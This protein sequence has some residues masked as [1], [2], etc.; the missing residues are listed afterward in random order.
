MKYKNEYA[1]CFSIKT[2]A[3][4]WFQSFHRRVRFLTKREV[5]LLSGHPTFPHVPT[6]MSHRSDHVHAGPALTVLSIV[7]RDCSV[8][9]TGRLKTPAV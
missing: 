1:K 7:I 5:P 3:Q 2:E 4:N 6:P 9:V 8:Y